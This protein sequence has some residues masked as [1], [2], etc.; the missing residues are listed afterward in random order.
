MKLYGGNSG[1]KKK[2]APEKLREKTRDEAY[3]VR[4]YEGEEDEPS[5]RTPEEKKHIEELI[6]KYQSYKRRKR[7]LIIAVLLVIAAALFFLL[8]SYIKPPDIPKT[9]P[10]PAAT[11]ATGTTPTPG[12]ST[13]NRKD[14]VYTF[15]ILGK[16]VEAGLTDTIL[17]G[18]FDTVNNNLNVISIPR[19]TLL[20]VTRSYKKANGIY[21]HN[22]DDIEKA[23]ADLKTLLGFSVD[24]HAVVDIKA[25]QRI[26]DTI[27]G[28]DFEVPVNMDYDDDIQEFHVHLMAG[29]QHLTGAQ[30]LGVV[31]FRQN[32]EGSPYGP[33]YPRADI[34]RIATQQSF[35]KTVAKQCLNIWNI[36]KID[37]FAQIFKDYVDTNLTAGNMAWF[38]QQF[39][40]VK[41][42][43]IK[44]MTLPGNYEDYE[45]GAACVTVKLDEWL[46][47]LNKIN[48]YK[49]DI[50]KD[51]LN[52]LT[53]DKNGKLYST[54][55]VIQ[56]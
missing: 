16:D 41:S 22:R 39:L 37:E 45:L 2:K 55:G 44:F 20:N 23:K 32:N 18:S 19:D 36:T 29:Q 10:T 46:E 28:V 9:T 54:S 26:V 7:I 30:A 21:S 14:G 50:T 6:D 51:H 40:N 8:K 52:V 48:P 25:F 5:Q 49:E 15:L 33:G 35:M 12:A 27:G 13:L 24:M 17:V 53:L 31:R 1:R 47:M 42:E 56:S 34:D 38:G 3:E 11:A 4:G 43:N